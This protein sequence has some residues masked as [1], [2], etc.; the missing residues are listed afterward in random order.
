MHLEGL[1]SLCIRR[2]TVQLRSILLKPHDNLLTIGTYQPPGKSIRHRWVRGLRPDQQMRGIQ[3]RVV[4]VVAAGF[5]DGRPLLQRFGD[6]EVRAP[7][8]DG[9][10]VE[11]DSGGQGLDGEGDVLVVPGRVGCCPGDLWLVKI[12]TGI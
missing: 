7:V 1:N 5:V 6:G 2:R 8:R 11:Q 9:V 10:L 12:C 3:E 4:R